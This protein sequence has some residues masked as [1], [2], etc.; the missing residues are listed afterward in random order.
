[1]ISKNVLKYSIIL[2]SLIFNFY[3]VIA[4]NTEL[5]IVENNTT[6]GDFWRGRIVANSFNLSE[7]SYLFE[8]RLYLNNFSFFNQTEYLQIELRDSNNSSHSLGLY[9]PDSNVGIIQ[10]FN[11]TILSSDEIYLK[12]VNKDLNP[13]FLSVK[14]VDQNI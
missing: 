6:Y 7:D 2:F 4:E 12:W 5:L 9:H 10:N 1:M 14:K 11:I 13:V 3:N 8:I